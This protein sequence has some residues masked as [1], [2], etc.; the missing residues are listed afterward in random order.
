MF[1]GV[2][3]GFPDITQLDYIAG[4]GVPVNVEPGGDLD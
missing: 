4:V 2:R 3:H 1:S